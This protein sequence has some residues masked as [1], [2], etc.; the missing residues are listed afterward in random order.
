M[1]VLAAVLACLVVGIADGDTLTVRCDA[2]AEQAAQTVIIR[3]AE[4]I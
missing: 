1:P 3:L 2:Q 4:G